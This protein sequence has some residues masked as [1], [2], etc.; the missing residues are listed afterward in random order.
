MYKNFDSVSEGRCQVYAIRSCQVAKLNPFLMSWMSFIQGQAVHGLGECS[1]SWAP[2]L[3]SWGIPG[4]SEWVL[5]KKLRKQGVIP[6]KAGGS[7]FQGK[8]S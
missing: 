1:A 6:R 8:V 4:K 2:G 7:Y 3:S 5:E